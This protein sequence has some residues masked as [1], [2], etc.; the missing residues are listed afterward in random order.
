[1]QM[2]YDYIITGSGCAGLSL[3]YSILKD[4]SLKTKKILVIDKN[5]DK[6]NDR[7]W[8]YWEKGEGLFEPIVTHQ[9][10]ELEFISSNF[11]R[12]FKL[13]HYSY[14]MIR[15]IDFYNFVLEFTKGSENVTFI[16]E[17][18]NRISVINE[19]ATVE[20]E[21]NKYFA[22]YVFNSTN[23]FNP[24]INPHNS[25]LQHFEGWFIKTNK[26]CFDHHIGTLM[27]F[28]LS[29][30]LGA[31]FMYVLPTKPNEALI[32]YTLFSKNILERDKYKLALENYIKDN[33]KI[34]EYEITHKEYGVIPMSMASFARNANSEKR[35]INIGTAGGFT[36]ASSGYTFQF[37]QKNTN[38]IVTNLRKGVSPNPK[39]TFREKMFQWYDKVLL[40]VL[41]SQKMTA[42]EIFSMMFKKIAPEKILSFLGN[43]SSFIDDIRIMNS[44]PKKINF[45]IAGIRRLK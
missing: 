36:K 19:C 42:K 24:Q 45:F 34:E 12:R 32:E 7:T 15:G 5:T 43:E 33:L 30:E 35:I 2:K 20:T 28:R 37:I 17:N 6:T 22:K 1:M 4:P 8:C 38:A 21:S 11:F 18:I 13:E 25:L 39:I 16:S 41:I 27:D 3:L 40:E 14:K 9:W 10:K 29:Q 26:Q 44:V 23:L 31:T